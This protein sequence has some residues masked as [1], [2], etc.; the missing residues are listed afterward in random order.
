MN[1]TIESI[2]NELI[3]DTK[4]IIMNYLKMNN[5][6]PDCL[7]DTNI[8]IS[9][10]IYSNKNNSEFISSSN[11]FAS[12]YFLELST[13]DNII[14]LFA[15]LISNYPNS[16][17]GLF[18][19]V[20]LQKH[21]IDI[22]HSLNSSDDLF[23][24]Y[25]KDILSIYNNVLPQKKKQKLLENICA[26]I[27]VLIIIGFQ[28][29]W[30]NGIDQLIS[31]AKIMEGKTENNLIAELILSNIDHI[32]TQLEKKLDKKSSDFILSLI[33]SY[34]YV[35]KDYICFLIQNSFS[36]DKQNFVNGDLFKAFI[37]VIRCFKYFKI[38]I[39][40]IHGFLDF[41]INCISYIDDNQAFITEI[42]DL[43]DDI[44][45][46]P[47][48]VLKY[49]YDNNFKLAEFN[50]FLIDIQKNEDF[51]EIS[52]CIKLIHNVKNYYSTKE[53]N[54]IKNNPKDMQILFASC[55]IFNSICENYG[56][57]FILP[58]IDDIVQDIHFYFINLPIFKIS[59]I[60]LSSLNDFVYLSQNNYKF[61]NYDD[62]KNIRENK[63]N[64]LNEFLYTVQNSVLQNMKLE[65][66]ELNINTN[67]K[68]DRVMENWLHLDPYMSDLLKSN[69]NDDEKSNFIENSKA[70]YE[71]IYNIISNLF[72]INDYCDKLCKYLLSSTEASDYITIDCLMNIFNQ[73][74]MEIITEKPDIIINMIDFIIK[75][76]DILFKSNRFVLQ[77]FKL[78]YNVSIQISKN[79]TLLNSI[80]ET[81][82]N[83]NIIKELKC[84]VLNDINIILINR[85]CLYSYQNYKLSE[86]DNPLS[87]N[88][89]D[90]NNIFNL[91]SK[92]LL[93]NLQTLNHF[94]LSK[95]VDAF[96]SSLFYNIKLNVINQ[97]SIY[98]ATEKLLTEVN[99]LYNQSNITINNLLKYIY[100]LWVIIKNIGIENKDALF[101]LLNKADPFYKESQSYLTM[102]QNNIINIIN[103]SN[104]DN[105]NENIMDAI[106]ILNTTLIAILKEK[107][108]QHFD[109]F[110]KII[111]L[112]VSINQKYIRIY[113]LTYSLYSQIF[114]F[115]SGSEVFNNISK[116]GFDILNSM[117]S[118]Y[119]NLKDDNE[120]VL[121]ASNQTEFMLLYF[122]KS[123][124]F[125]NN[126]NLKMEIFI[127]SLNNI[128]NLFDKSNQRNFAINFTSLIKLIVDLSLKNNM[129][130]NVLS[131]NFVEKITK[132]IINNVQY[133][134]KFN[135]ICIQNCYNIFSN[136]VGTPMEEKFCAGLNDIYNDKELI[137]I[138]LKFINYLK[139]NKDMRKNEMDKKIREFF[140]DLSELCYAMY[141]KRNEFIKK[142]DDIM[143]TIIVNEENMRSIKVN[144]NSEIH[145][146]LF[147]Q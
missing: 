56:Y 104:N 55:N 46:S 61:E 110:N 97:D 92:F 40:Q 52:K 49:D 126:L 19:A 91:L 100:L 142:Y 133:F 39:I 93:D 10:N 113:S 25:Q 135:F 115:N 118:I 32:F 89:K 2:D 43:F 22:S 147:A 66:E 83:N 131:E 138:I 28:G 45:K 80:L 79:V 86:E 140:K 68:S 24:K 33:D 26:S 64:K 71:D 16:E 30:A 139:N 12:K 3:F 123:T 112:I 103:S 62:N 90:L 116:I 35:V 130:G 59:Q 128:I 101:N 8:Q 117:N 27:T 11:K 127:Q 21:V 143:N 37:G 17:L 50:K 48:K 129:I 107:V 69:I 84:E 20:L 42:C 132:I 53:I 85:L 7:K 74:Y 29:Q 81:L 125:I 63:K 146:N 102:I 99:Q 18:L 6:N 134:E 36:G 88:N 124:D 87:V 75:K 47:D 95:L 1:S 73:L 136:L 38:N 5:F 65:K 96:Y 60:L 98:S 23:K 109:Y 120:K 34:S 106:I 72:D 141:Q 31:A 94:Y 145:M 67:N 82:I 15:P 137:S 70:F 51:Q 57:I 121:L 77:F 114:C 4:H 44:F 108:S 111:S 14:D 105:F 9:N 76:K 13:K 119:A 78:I 144:L 54:E 41:L 122:Q 58:E